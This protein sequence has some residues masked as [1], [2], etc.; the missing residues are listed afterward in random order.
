MA[1]GVVEGGLQRWPST[2]SEP[3]PCRRGGKSHQNH[4][5]KRKDEPEQEFA[6][7]ALP[8]EDET[9][10]EPEEGRAE[11]LKRRMFYLYV[12]LPCG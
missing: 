7:A 3:L 2:T 9:G 1:W 4:G 8:A 12:V 11:V 6:G 5:Q 10:T